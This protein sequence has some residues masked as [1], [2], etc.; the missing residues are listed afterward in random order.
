VR[1]VYD[2]RDFEDAC[3]LRSLR[4]PITLEDFVTQFVGKAPRPGLD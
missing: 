2:Y 1:A 4:A 3:P